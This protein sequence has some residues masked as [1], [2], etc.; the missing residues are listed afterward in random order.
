MSEKTATV[1]I[2]KVYSWSE[3]FDVRA[4]FTSWSSEYLKTKDGGSTTIRER[5]S[6]K[7]ATKSLV[8]KSD[9]A[10]KMKTSYGVYF[11]AAELPYRSLYIG[12]AASDSKSP[13]GILK[14]FQKHRVKITGSHVGRDK[15]KCG[16]V[17]H[18]QGWRKFAR[19]RLSSSKV[20]FPDVCEDIRFVIAHV[21]LLKDSAN[22]K[23]WC[24]YIE[25]EFVH[26]QRRTCE[27]V[28][29]FWP[30]AEVSSIEVITSRTTKNRS[31]PNREEIQFIFQ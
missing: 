4:D 11:V 27:I 26:N 7:T 15:E 8:P 18:T 1:F 6:F 16:G 5:S 22:S 29:Q 20:P 28:D 19:A 21:V 2:S 17:S 9:F 23:E 13:E 3:H 12:I 24:E 10:R 25:Q 30:D 31:A 14:R